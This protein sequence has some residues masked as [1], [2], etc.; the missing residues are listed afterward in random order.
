MSIGVGGTK[1]RLLVIGMCAIGMI[2]ASSGLV[3]AQRT[4]P[5]T[6][7]QNNCASGNVTTTSTLQIGGQGSLSSNGAAFSNPGRLDDGTIA[8][9]DFV[10]SY[11]RTTG[12]LTLQ[13]FNRTTTT[14]SLTGLSFNTPPGV[15]AMTL[16][17]ETGSLV[18]ERAFDSNRTDNVVD[19]H[20]SSSLKNIKMD[21]MGAFNVLLANN[22]ASTSPGGGNPAE[23]LAGQNVTFTIQVS[24]D[25]ANYTACSFTSLPSVIPPGDKVMIAVARFQSGAQGGSGF[26]TPCGPGDLLISLSSFSVE[27]GDGR[28][29]VRWETSSEIDNAGFAVLRKEARS[30][31]FER[32]TN[33][34][35]P[36]F[37][38]DVS[39]ASYSFEDTTA[40]NGVKY[41]YMLE[42][43]D[44]GGFNTIH[45]PEQTVPN[46]KAPPLRLVDPAYDA[47][48][49]RVVT[50]KWQSD[51]PVPA[52]ILISADPTFPQESTMELPAGAGRTR[53]LSP[54]ER[55]QVHQMAVAGEG[56]VYWRVVG[57]SAKGD[58]LNSQTWF[59]VVE[60]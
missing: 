46:P 26:I 35:L 28:V 7:N 37:G 42:D 20:P 43:F 52:R 18:W 4:C 59:L 31:R 6:F 1:V 44:L 30:G 55:S 19:S 34:L 33:T 53:K 54:R 36:G 38:S 57:R 12:E 32:V 21:G 48:A 58:V 2:A 29:T 27:P 17:S 13:V 25:I 47:K 11:N 39:G 10:F 50:L 24:G 3:W 8:E 60:D 9:A 40:V 14:A 56:G 41:H 16:V 23:I 22:G 45:P 5:S 51:Q 15:T 49:G